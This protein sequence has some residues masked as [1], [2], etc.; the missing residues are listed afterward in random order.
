MVDYSR[1]VGFR[2]GSGQVHGK[3]TGCYFGES[4]GLGKVGGSG[5]KTTPPALEWWG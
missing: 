1:K 4:E 5:G 3:E 2:S